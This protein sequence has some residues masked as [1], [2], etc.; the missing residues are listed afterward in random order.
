MLFTRPT[1]LATF[2]L[3]HIT[4]AAYATEDQ[5]NILPTIS[6]KAQQDKNNGYVATQ[7]TST[8]KSNAPLFKTAQ[9]VTVITQEQLQQKQAQTLA[10]ALN[11][12]AGVVS[13]QLG[14]RGWDDFIIRGQTS[15]DQV[16][17]DGLRQGQSTF[18]ATEISGMDQVQV[19]KGPASVNFGLVQPGGMV[20]MV[21][22]RPQ[23]ESF[24]RS[25]ITYGSH[26]LKQAT[27][28]INYSPNESEKGAFRLNGRI[29]DQNDPTD[30]VYFKNYYISP[31]YNFDLGDKTDLSVIASFQHREY[32]RQQGLPV[33]GTLI[34]NPNGAIDRS[35][36]IGDPNFGQYKAD[37]YRT[38]YTFKHEFGNGWNFN[39]NFAVQKTEMDG[40]AVFAQTKKFWVDETFTTIN[41]SKNSRHQIADN[42]SYSIDNQL[43]KEFMLYGV[44]HY[45]TVGL[46]AL[47]E[48]SDYTNNKYD[49]GGINIYDPIYGQETILTE[50]V[51]N[52]NRLRYTGL[53][54]RDRIELND[55]LV[56]NLAG[57]H[58]WTETTTQNLVK[59][60]ETTQSENAFTGNAS[61]LYGINEIAAPYVSYATS[62]LPVS[63]TDFH[64]NAFKPEK[65]KQIEVGLKLQSPDQR[66]QG[67]IAWFD[68]RRQNVSVTDPINTGFKVQRGEQLTRG[69]ETELAA[70]LFDQLKIT[71]AYT[72]TPD[73]E[74]SKDTQAENIG[75]TIDNVPEHSYSLSTRYRFE[76]NSNLGWYVGAG[77]RGE[78]KKSVNGLTVDLPSYTL[79]DT[80]AG[81]D[82]EHW[83][84]QLAIRN[85]FDKDYYAGALNENLVALG[86]PRQINFT[87]KFNY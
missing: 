7:A 56:L 8:L 68:L 4:S 10:E 59:N 79:F 86:N 66:I 43:K 42:L 21:T 82:A 32:L 35:L 3:S 25:A 19:L 62:F 12:V 77:V 50:N 17:I 38:G 57:R 47:Q 16:F 14:R 83:G 24:Y 37:V 23:A 65:G 13:G 31:S 15:S 48:K 27:F 30:F 53:Y 2:I 9:S 22:K 58:D 80:E 67:S 75:L 20:N 84:A 40:K 5:S 36:Y 33:L 39:Q 1:L 49:I 52:I 34:D 78:S 11:G 61:L 45:L 60:T 41:R 6:I 51:H 76:P 26:Q 74:I 28:D 73:A 87:V 85:M 70:H 29:S 18:V 44:K 54:L 64:D 69:I 55:Q 81:Y 71:A 46:D 63:G 72:Y